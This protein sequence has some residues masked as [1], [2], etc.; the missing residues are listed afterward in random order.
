[1][2]LSDHEDDLNDVTPPSTFDLNK[3]LNKLGFVKFCDW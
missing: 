3:K 2:T 1:M